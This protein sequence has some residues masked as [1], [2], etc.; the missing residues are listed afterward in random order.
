ML[1]C[2]L[3]FYQVVCTTF[4]NKAALISRI[5]SED[6]ALISFYFSPRTCE[7]YTPQSALRPP[8]VF[9]VTFDWHFVICHRL[10]DNW[11]YCK[12]R[13]NFQKEDIE[14]TYPLCLSVLPSYTVF[15]SFFLYV[16][17]CHY[18]DLTLHFL[19]QR[20]YFNDL[21]NLHASFASKLSA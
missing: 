13:R 6:I 1:T 7:Q 11:K 21:G 17:P 3:E 15:M 10:L 18:I 12:K 5:T 20:Q 19:L 4:S 8:N 14:T 2:T 9:C 16:V